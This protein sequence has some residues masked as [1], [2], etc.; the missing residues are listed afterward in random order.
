[1]AIASAFFADSSRS[2]KSTV[3][4]VRLHSI[5]FKKRV[6]PAVDL[7]F[8]FFSNGDTNFG[9]ETL[10]FFDGRGDG[11]GEG[12]SLKGDVCGGDGGPP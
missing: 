7:L 12:G 5:P 10:D 1:V 4:D 2:A 8:F 11:R 9:I 3:S 6:V